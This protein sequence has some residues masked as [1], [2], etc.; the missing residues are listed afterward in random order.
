MSDEP[1]HGAAFPDDRLLAGIR[2]YLAPDPAV[3]VSIVD[4]SLRVLYANERQVDLFFGGSRPDSA[5]TYEAL[6]GARWA[7]ERRTV[8]DQI[9]ATGRPAIF[10]HIRLGWQLQSTVR[11][12][13][14]PGWPE[15]RF[16]ALTT[17]GE[18][19]PESAESFTIVE[20]GLV[21][22]GPLDP[23]TRR[24]I[25]VLA[26]IGHNLT[27]RQIAELLSISPRTVERHRDAISQKLGGANMLQM[28]EFA[29]HAG[30]RL[31]DAWLKRY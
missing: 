3:G 2:R 21:S 7:A 1:S 5:T 15:P 31:E 10:R 6:F 25:E 30:L 4:G 8:Y 13:T 24:E 18:H 12:L 27:T 29:H 17:L 23:L 20:S 16:L 9:A 19:H 26:L 14:A 28:T 11:L 22:L